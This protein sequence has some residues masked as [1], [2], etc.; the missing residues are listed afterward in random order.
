M[1]ETTT[2]TAPVS[3][4]DKINEVLGEGDK[5]TPYKVANAVNSLFE[6]FGV[7]KQIPTMMAYNYCKNGLI[8]GVSKTTVATKKGTREAVSVSREGAVAWI[9]KYVTKNL[10]K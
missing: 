4:E 5:F 9:S 3:L 6:S 10:P 1:S 2:T 7:S 8:K